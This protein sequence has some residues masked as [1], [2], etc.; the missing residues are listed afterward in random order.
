MCVNAHPL[1]LSARKRGGIDGNGGTQA[2]PLPFP[3]T[4]DPQRELDM[5]KPEDAAELYRDRAQ[6]L[7]ERALKAEYPMDR[8]RLEESARR[9]E[10][11]ADDLQR[12][13]TRASPRR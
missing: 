4:V 10:T 8:T 3:V 9:F 11:L 1:H 6:A 2:Q 7:R 5:P 12:G 13:Q